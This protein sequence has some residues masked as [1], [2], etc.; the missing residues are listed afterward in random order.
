[1]EASRS[2][3]SPFY[4]LRFDDLDVENVLH[5][6]E[7]VKLNSEFSSPPEH[8]NLKNKVTLRAL[9]DHEIEVS[10]ER[11]PIQINLNS[12]GDVTVSVHHDA[13]TKRV[14]GQ[15][16]IKPVADLSADPKYF[17]RKGITKIQIMMPSII[18]AARGDCS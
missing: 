17:R 16:E 2:K 14:V 13:L 7:S 15:G 5:D 1:M 8:F 12:S 18:E 11:R 10:G 3:D 9:K 6:V 4:M